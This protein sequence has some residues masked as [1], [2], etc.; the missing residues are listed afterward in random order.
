MHFYMHSYLHK[1]FILVKSGCYTVAPQPGMELLPNQQQ[2][3][4]EVQQARARTR[5]IN[6]ERE[7]TQ[8]HD[9]L[10]GLHAALNAQMIELH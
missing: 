1:I 10:A 7:A 6:A 8:H 5:Q 4:H 9:K 3:Y 2:A